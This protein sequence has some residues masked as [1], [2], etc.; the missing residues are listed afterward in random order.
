MSSC[1]GRGDCIQQ[2]GCS[3]YY[4]EDFNIPCEVCSCGHRNHTKMIGG[5]SESDVYCKSECA[6]N[7]NLVECHNYK[8]CGQ[9]RPQIIL[10]SHNGMCMDCAIIIGRVKFLD[11]KDDCT[12]C[13]IN[14]H[15]IEVSCGKHKFCLDCWKRWS[16]TSTQIPLTCPLCRNPIWK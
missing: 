4:D 1:N 15:M 5:D 8:M 9:K 14:K 12:I 7:C 2:C 16:K 13:S 6:H 10:D 3:C 11:E